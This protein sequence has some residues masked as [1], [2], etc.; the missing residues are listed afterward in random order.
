[1]AIPV[2]MSIL[3]I[4]DSETMSQNSSERETEQAVRAINKQFAIG[5]ELADRF[6]S[7]VSLRSLQNI[8]F[9]VCRSANR[10]YSMM[11]GPSAGIER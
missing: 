8:H 10:T 6:E 1:M 9:L 11:N 4:R 2:A 7:A 5:I 3:E